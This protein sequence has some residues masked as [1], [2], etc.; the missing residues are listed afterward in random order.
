[1]HQYQVRYIE[2]D[3]VIDLRYVLAKNKTDAK[4]TA[5]NEGC[6]DIL[7]VKRVA[8]VHLPILSLIAAVVLLAALAVIYRVI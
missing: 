2:R 8:P 5:E 3:G 4:R 1:M 7:S 6:E